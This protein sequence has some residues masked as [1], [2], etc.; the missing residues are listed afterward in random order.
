M[1][2]RSTSEAKHHGRDAVN[3]TVLRELLRGNREVKERDLWMTWWVDKPESEAERVLRKLEA[4][5]L[6]H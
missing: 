5:R 1:F 6:G 2:L 4:K 3:A